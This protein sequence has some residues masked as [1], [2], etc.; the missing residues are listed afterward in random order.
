MDK[1]QTVPKEGIGSMIVYLSP[2]RMEEANEAIVFALGFDAPGLGVANVGVGL[3]AG[4]CTGRCTRDIWRYSQASVRPRGRYERHVGLHRPCCSAPRRSG[5][6]MSGPHSSRPLAAIPRKQIGPIS[7]KSDQS[8][9]FPV[10]GRPVLLMG[11][12]GWSVMQRSQARNQDRVGGS[13]G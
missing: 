1:N 3:C 11:C 5:P 13:A 9:L 4:H 8:W 6:S 10:E 2:E 12:W 7:I